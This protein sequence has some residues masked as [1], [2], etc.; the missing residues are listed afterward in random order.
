M[1]TIK[2]IGI[3]ECGTSG[4]NFHT[5]HS[6][7]L[8]GFVVSKILV[9]DTSAAQMVHKQYPN[10]ELVFDKASI[11]NDN[12]IDMVILSEPNE[13]ELFMV[14]EILQAGKQVRIL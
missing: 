6:A 1:H 7:H 2:N 12:T 13:T 5:N 3:I 14:G 11:L 9:A 8:N 10:T 4:K